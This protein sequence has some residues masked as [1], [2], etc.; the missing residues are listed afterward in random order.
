MLFQKTYTPALE[1][2]AAPIFATLPDPL[3]AQLVR[4]MIRLRSP[5]VDSASEA[6]GLLQPSISHPPDGQ[7]A[8]RTRREFCGNF[9][10]PIERS[11]PQTGAGTIGRRS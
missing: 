10:R 7:A 2:E 3:A 1:A 9:V 8:L 6:H 4:E 11:L 5:K